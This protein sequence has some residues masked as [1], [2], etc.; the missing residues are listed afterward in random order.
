LA[1]GYLAHQ[2]EA[3]SADTKRKRLF[4]E[5][6]R[7]LWTAAVQLLDSLKRERPGETVYAFL[8]EVNMAGDLVSAAAATEEGLD[9]LTLL[10]LSEGFQSAVLCRQWLRWQYYIRREGWYTKNEGNYF[11][12]VQSLLHQAIGR[13]LMRKRDGKLI[14]IC[15]E[16]LQ[17]MDAD[18]EFDEYAVRSQLVLGLYY[19]GKDADQKFIEWAAS[20]NPPAVVERLRQ[21]IMATK[22]AGESLFGTAPVVEEPPASEFSF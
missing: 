19:D 5:I 1:C 10:Y 2:I 7:L 13:G 15:L 12:A 20:V 4:G 11:K 21:E 17:A 18:G 14:Q 9:R 6:R 3:R 22:T 8:F 16:T